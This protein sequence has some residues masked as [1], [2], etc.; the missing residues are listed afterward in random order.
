MPC[1]LLPVGHLGV[2][3][4]PSP[5]CHFLGQVTDVLGVSAG[6]CAWTD[7][8]VATADLRRG[9]FWWHHTVRH[10]VRPSPDPGFGTQLDER[11]ASHGVVVA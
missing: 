7:A 11:R 2:P 9:A 6:G 1:A 5:L 3:G 4:C 10:E 8:V